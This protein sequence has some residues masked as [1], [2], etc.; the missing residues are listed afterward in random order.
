ME[1]KFREGKRNKN[2]FKPQASAIFRLELRVRQMFLFKS[3]AIASLRTLF[4][5]PT[6]K[7]FLSSCGDA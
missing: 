1:G 6:E 5:K 3:N 2:F 7:S 4:A